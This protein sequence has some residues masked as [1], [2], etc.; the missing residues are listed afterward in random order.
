MATP[1]KT[2]YVLVNENALKTWNLK[3]YEIEEI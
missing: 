1:D 2:K 3:T